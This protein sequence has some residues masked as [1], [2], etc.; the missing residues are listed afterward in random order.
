MDYLIIHV[1]DDDE[2]ILKVLNYNKWIINPIIIIMKIEY[3][4]MGWIFS[5][6]L[7]KTVPIRHNITYYFNT[8][9][10][11]ILDQY[12]ECVSLK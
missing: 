3:E 5:V 8:E 7:T 2:R 10:Y 12:I 11:S 9:V 4:L 6:M 1:D